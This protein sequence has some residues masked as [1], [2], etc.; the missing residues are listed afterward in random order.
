MADSFSFNEVDLCAYGLR[1]RSHEEPFDQETPAAQLIDKAY[2]FN[3]LR[4]PKTFTLDVA[5]SAADKATLLSYLDSI[6][7]TL[8]ERGDCKLT[9]D[10][11]DD[12]YWMARFISMDGQI[13]TARI[14]EGTITFAVNDPAAYDN[15]ETELKIIVIENSGLEEGDP[16]DGWEATGAGATLER[17]TEQVKIGSYSGK[18]N[19]PVSTL[20]KMIKYLNNYEYYLGK[21]IT[22]AAWVYASVAGRIAVQIVEGGTGHSTTGDSHTGDSAFQWLTVT[23]TINSSGVTYTSMNTRADD[24]AAT[25]VYTDGVILVEGDSIPDEIVTTS[26]FIGLDIGGTEK[27]RPVYTFTCDDTLTDTTV[28]ITNT[29]TGEAIE[30]TGDLVADDVLE[31]DAGNFTVKLNGV[32]DMTTVDGQFPQLLPGNNQITI[33]GF[34]GPMSI[35]YRERYV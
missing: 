22:L 7:G 13:K 20:S 2:G 19:V 28:I 3:S 11:F 6:K 30:W 1:L 12:R 8:N 29:A 5:V 16:P 34:T 26:P 14:W 17:S 15:D 4:P 32:E 18:L 9:L 31:I 21:T 27:V 35:V 10:T 23:R 33:E 25:A 24:G